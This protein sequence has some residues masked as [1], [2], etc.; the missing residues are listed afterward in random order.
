MALPT[1]NFDSGESRMLRI[2][3]ADYQ[4]R[5]R[6]LVKA[7]GGE[8]NLKMVLEMVTNGQD[9][10]AKFPGPHRDLA[11]VNKDGGALGSDNPNGRGVV[12]AFDKMLE[13]GRHGD[14]HL[15]LTEWAEQYGGNYVLPFIRAGWG[16]ALMPA[17]WV[18]VA[19]PD[20]HMR[21]T[22]NH[23]KKAPIYDG[24]NFGRSFLAHIDNGEWQRRRFGNIHSVAPS[25]I[26]TY[27]HRM[28]RHVNRMSAQLTSAASG[29][30]MYG[31]AGPEPVFNVHE[32]VSDTAFRVAADT[33]FG[34][35]DDL[36]AKWSRRIRWALNR[37]ERDNPKAVQLQREWYEALK[38]LP[39]DRMGPMLQ[40][41]ME[42]YD[43][44]EGLG[45]DEETLGDK[46]KALHDDIMIMT[47]AMHDTTAATISLCLMEL[48]RRPA[49]QDRVAEEARAVLG[50]RS[51]EATMEYADLY[52]MPLLTKC[53]NET[54][55]VW[56]A[57]SYGSQRELETDE[58]LH[59]GPGPDDTCVVPAG[60][61]VLVHNFAQHRNKTLW[62]EDADEW[63]VDRWEGFAERGSINF[64]SGGG[65]D[66]TDGD[67]KDGDHYT[68]TYSARNPQSIRFHPFTRAPRD[69]FGKNFAQAEMRVVL[70]ILL[71]R[72]EFA[73]AEPTKSKVEAGPDAYIYQIAGVVKPRD[74]LWMTATPRGECGDAVPPPPPTT[75]TPTTTSSPQPK[76]CL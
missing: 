59:C 76:A 65:D 62:G 2:A 71:S 31:G 68:T 60:T 64:D 54:L 6:L 21:V 16:E 73:L 56:P 52:R 3:G 57:V 15:L 26:K 58:V 17:A 28:E 44:Y 33:L 41:F 27:F 45:L 43:E 22:T 19:H 49:L 34:L 53:I 47:F 7:V 9:W 72:F 36:A 66:A 32:L 40:S 51:G 46:E 11:S 50:Q 63:R 20:D 10:A 70:P 69:C 35:T 48:A 4:K 42:Q 13:S 39:R 25:Y 37:P 5:R 1:Q 12:A 18:V 74:G 30:M 61:I 75:T 14:Q 55:R 24:I 67:A 29:T 23:V 38:A 8:E